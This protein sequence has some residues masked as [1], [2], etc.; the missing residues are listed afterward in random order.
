MNTDTNTKATT[1]AAAAVKTTADAAA[2]KT[3]AAA[4]AAATK[5]T[6]AAAAAKTTAAA[7]KTTAATTP[8]PNTNISELISN[9]FT[10][11]NMSLV[12]IFL[13]IYVILY[14]GLGM[15]FNKT[16][17]PV[18]AQ[19]ALSRTIDILLFGLFLF[20]LVTSYFSLSEDDKEHLFGYLLQWSKDFWNDPKTIMELILSTIIFY[21]FVYLCRI[22]MTSETQPISIRFIENKLWVLLVIQLFLDFFKYV[23]NIRII[24]IIFGDSLIKWSN[25]INTPDI[26]V[27]SSSNPVIQNEVFN[28]SN[29]LYTYDDAQAICSSYDAQMATYDQVENSYTK[30]GEWCNFG[31]SDGQ[32]ALFPTQKNTWNK[33]QKTDNHKNDCGRPGVNGG[34]IANPYIKFGVNCFGKKPKPSSAETARMDQGHTQEYPKTLADQVVDAKVKFWKENAAK[35]LN[36]NSFN[37]DKWT[38]Y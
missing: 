4:D 12:L 32:M 37:K 19:L 26:T 14:F 9:I 1:D 23:F 8:P 6:A 7:A 24:D 34:Y 33:L 36:L 10:Q 29:N 15:Y 35:M 38:E 22:P 30:G 25:N 31:W 3:T 28:V 27:D 5:T 16:E 2:A 21:I 13:A 17:N 18:G 11:S 20:I